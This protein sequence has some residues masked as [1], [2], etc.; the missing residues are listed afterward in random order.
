[1]KKLF[2]ECSAIIAVTSVL[3]MF[4]LS[5]P[6][7]IIAL[8]AGSSCFCVVIVCRY[9]RKRIA[10]AESS[11]VEME[12]KV[13]SYNY[14][15]QVSASQIASVSK[16]LGLT[17]SENNDYAADLFEK[18]KE[19]TLLNREVSEDI[20][21]VLEAE[22]QLMTMIEQSVQDAAAMQEIGSLSQ[23]TVMKSIGSIM[24]IV[25][26]IG[27]IRKSSDMTV[28]YME[29]L[30]QT[31]NQII[32]ILESVEDISE[33]THLL[34][35]N[36]AIESARAGIA[37]KGFA[38]VSAEI[39]KLSTSTSDAVKNVSSLIS[40][41]QDE[42]RNVSI[43]VKSNTAY[44]MKG[45]SISKNVE[46][47]L[48]TICRS[49]ESV[50]AKVGGI[51]DI[52]AIEKQ[53]GSDIEKKAGDV[54]RTVSLAERSV[55]SVYD[56]VRTQKDHMN[57]LSEM[58]KRLVTAS[59]SLTGLFDSSFFSGA[60]YLTPDLEE[61]IKKA[62]DIMDT[63]FLSAK[64]VSARDSSVHET[65]ISKLVA[66]YPFIEAAWT[67]DEKGRFII[68]VPPAGIANAGV[69]DWF[70]ESVSGRKYVSGVYISA[71]TKNPCITVSKPF[72]SGSGEI[73]GVVGFD[74][75]LVE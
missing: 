4:L 26:T 59:S 12:K 16:E 40:G 69:R 38:V 46:E 49:F 28:V 74:I 66:Q 63:S 13:G 52:S 75:R 33:Q 8:M 64:D 18:T 15:V 57:D 51:K 1:M 25:G 55:T 44:V 22:M 2:M 19:M 60:N 31:S 56:A 23:K 61:K 62:F 73:L 42:I 58:S 6:F 41:I 20:K 71:I 54:N 30:E 72:M 24:E 9:C 50:M 7:V 10:A 5:V 53:F 37:G 68:S 21:G 34:A 45:V 11:V 39:G 47:D 32:S 43:M 29:K 70:K 17:F 3:S 27:E 35:L 67:N 36:A 65:I 48:G 14:E